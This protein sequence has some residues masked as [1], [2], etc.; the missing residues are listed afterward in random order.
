MMWILFTMVSLV[1]WSSGNI[2]DKAVMMKLSNSPFA[3]YMI[4][5]TYQTL[6]ILLTFVILQPMVGADLIV[7]SICSGLLGNGAFLALI[8]SLQKEEVSRVIP[9]TYLSNI[10]IVLFSTIFLGEIFQPITYFGVTCLIVGAGLLSYQHKSGQ[11]LYFTSALIYIIAYSIFFASMTIVN[12]YILEFTTP[13]FLQI[14][15]GLG[16]VIVLLGM[17]SVKWMRVK[18]TTILQIPKKQ[19]LII[20]LSQLFGF[21][22][23]ISLLM[24]LS[25][26]TATLVSSLSIVKPLIVL[27][28]TV[29]LSQFFPHILLEDRDTK[30]IIIQLTATPLIMLGTIITLIS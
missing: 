5:V 11:K 14:W 21:L 20:G 22:G 19:H 8:I 3:Y 2:I 6:F 1:L 7:L 15:S 16:G 13:W 28:F 26:G 4:A 25:L 10:F 18:F 29:L 23:F 30:S 24:A 17:L 9:L 12:K 27:I